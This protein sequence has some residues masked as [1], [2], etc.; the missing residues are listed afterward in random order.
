MST[1]IWVVAAVVVF[2]FLQW[3]RLMRGYIAEATEYLRWCHR[4]FTDEIARLR[5]ASHAEGIR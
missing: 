3:A 5:A 2:S 4:E 1:P